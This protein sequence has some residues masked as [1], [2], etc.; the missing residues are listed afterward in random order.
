MTLYLGTSGWNYKHW[1]QTFYPESLPQSRWL[2]Y[3]FERFDTVELNNSFYRLPSREQFEKWRDQV[4]DHFIFTVKMNR[5]VTHIKRLRDP[6]EPVARFMDAALGLGPKLGPVLVQLPPNLK[7][8]L[9]ALEEVLE[10]FSDGVRLAVEFRHDSWFDEP[11]RALLEKYGAAW[12]LADRG[13]RP[14]TPVWGSA[15]WTFLRFHEG[16]ATPHPCYGRTALAS[17]VE[18]V[19][20]MWSAA[21]DVYVYFN[22]DPR[23]CALRDA[24]IF[25]RL[26]RRAGLDVTRTPNPADVR[27]G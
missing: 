20:S 4:P 12:C 27:L 26:A 16:A 2:Q 6:V 19:S 9:A 1:R 24:I 15:D 5:Y 14:I 21:S 11:V 25:G 8:D 22:N 13:S 3:F 10:Q 7:V 17:W 23:A 18:R